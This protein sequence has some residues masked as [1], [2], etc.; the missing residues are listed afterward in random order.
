[1]KICS[2]K[3]CSAKNHFKKKFQKVENTGLDIIK[4]GDWE[5]IEKMF[6]DWT[7]PQKV[8][9]YNFEELEYK[10]KNY[11]KR[12]K[13]DLIN[14]VKHIFDTVGEINYIYIRNGKMTFYHFYNNNPK[15]DWHQ[16]IDFHKYGSVENYYRE[17]QRMF[18]KKFFPPLAKPEDWKANNCLINIENYKDHN[19][20]ILEVP[21]YVKRLYP[22]FCYALKKYKFP[23]CDLL[24][25]RKDFPILRLDLRPSYINLYPK[26]KKIDL[27][28][29]Y[30]VLSQCS[31]NE[32][33]DIPIPT[34]D[35]W[36]A[37]EETKEYLTKWEDKLNKVVFRGT[38]TGC[39]LGNNNP[40]IYLHNEG[41]KHKELDIGITRVNQRNRVNQMKVDFHKERKF[42]VN[43]YLSMEEQSKYK[44]ILDIE[45]NA[46]AYRLGSVFNLHSCNLKYKSKFYLWFE[47]KL[48][49]KYHYIKVN[50]VNDILNEIQYDRRNKEIANNSYEF[51][52]E[53][54]NKDYLTKY[55][56]KISHM[57]NNLHQN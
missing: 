34:V 37:T 32:H 55:L 43:N 42:Q 50:N 2:A 9:K 46:A 39:E 30:P 12:N 53:Y 35:C 25:N 8:N 1:M 22:M 44:Y 21:N 47:Y 54:F 31:T 45:G 57:I 24:F 52:K 13:L 29:Q 20:T 4:Y 56:F 19:N 17:K 6:E 7:E 40:R 3:N 49:D 23:D 15:N 11:G 48:K 26:D 27:T 18:P 41:L 38:S 14:T 16:N 10:F 51:Y 5:K 28:N 36:D 33:F